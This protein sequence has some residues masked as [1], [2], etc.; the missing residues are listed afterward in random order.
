MTNST[1]FDINDLPYVQDSSRISEEQMVAG[2]VK[3]QVGL[4]SEFLG[5]YG[6]GVCV[7]E[8]RNPV[9]PKNYLM[10]NSMFRYRGIDSR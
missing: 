10:C 7:N 3:F 2:V 9:N 4:V 5:Y 8:M 6:P 1:V